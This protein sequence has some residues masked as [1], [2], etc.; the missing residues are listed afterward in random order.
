MFKT[1]AE[2]EVLIGQLLQRLDPLIEGIEIVLCP[3]FTDLPLVG[4]LID[5]S[6]WHLGAQN[7]HWERQGAFTGEISPSMLVGLGCRYVIVGHSERRAYFG[8]SD[9]TVNRK[10]KAALAAGLRPILCVGETLA[11]REQGRT[12]AVVERQLSGG[13]DGIDQLS[14]VDLVAAYEPV[15]AIGTGVPCGAGEAERVSGF[16]RE[17]LGRLLG[18]GTAEEIRIQYGGSVKPGNIA[19]FTSRPGIDGAL[20]GGASLEADSFA[21]LI[22]EALG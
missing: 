18:D 19:Q 17:V 20:V 16:I 4:K 10:V 2:A 9:E 6:K 22:R 11:E 12:E 8:E 7:I 14:G 5:G 21:T 13:L 3:P 1:E 15:W